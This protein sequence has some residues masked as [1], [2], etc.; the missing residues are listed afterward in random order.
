M[1]AVAWDWRTRP[2]RGGAA[3]PLA[4]ARGFGLIWPVRSA[5][6]ASLSASY[7]MGVT[8]SRSFVVEPDGTAVAV[9]R[10]SRPYHLHDSG[11]EQLRRGSEG[12]DASRPGTTREA[13][14]VR[15]ETKVVQA[16]RPAAS[17]RRLD[18]GTA[19][20][21]QPSHTC[22]PPRRGRINAAGP[23]DESVRDE[24]MGGAI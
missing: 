20:I 21:R 19:A 3:S 16:H 4:G 22:I 5:P 15:R 6:T 8:G 18:C 9:L 14:R 7:R 17:S 10:T 23:R 24:Q 11:T 13:G 12:R 2:R 1:L